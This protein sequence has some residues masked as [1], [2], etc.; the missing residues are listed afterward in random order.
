[1]FSSFTTRSPRQSLL[2][3]AATLSLSPSAFAY[4]PG[5]TAYDA[6]SQ[7]AA[8]QTLIQVATSVGLD[9]ALKQENL[10]VLLPSKAALSGLVGASAN[11]VKD[12]LASHVFLN[13]RN[14]LFLGDYV[15]LN[16]KVRIL[17]TSYPTIYVSRVDGV[18]PVDQTADGLCA[19]LVDVDVETGGSAALQYSDRGEIVAIG[20]K[21]ITVNACFTR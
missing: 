7:S 4:L 11:Q 18:T 17:K 13:T 2:I 5:R 15:S 1:M 14:K 19:R 9:G 20:S 12:V 21:V 10:I 6:L 8:G 16:G 3:I